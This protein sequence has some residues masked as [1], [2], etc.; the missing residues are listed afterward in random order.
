MTQKPSSRRVSA[1]DEVLATFSGCSVKAATASPASPAM[2]AGTS[3][4]SD[5]SRA[6]R[7][8]RRVGRR[9]WGQGARSVRRAYS[10]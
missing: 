5:T 2:A 8:Q 4:Y 7:A 6:S 3:Q 9:S 1:Y 10:R